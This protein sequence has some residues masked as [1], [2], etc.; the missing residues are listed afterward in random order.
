ME[1][2]IDTSDLFGHFSKDVNFYCKNVKKDRDVLL[3]DYGIQYTFQASYMESA[4]LE[5][6]IG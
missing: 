5:G 3:L 6:E 4:T 2:W 1:K